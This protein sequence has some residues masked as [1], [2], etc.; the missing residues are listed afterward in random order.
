MSSTQT[1]RGV[2][3]RWPR[4]DADVVIAATG[5]LHHPNVPEFSGIALVQFCNTPRPCIYA[6][7][8]RTA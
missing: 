4:V 1:T 5:V 3:T 8:H 6:V 7:K 2:A